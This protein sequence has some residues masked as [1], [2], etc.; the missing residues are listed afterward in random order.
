MSRILKLILYFFVYQLACSFVLTFLFYIPVVIR[1]SVENGTLSFPPFV[2]NSETTVAICAVTISNLLF[3]WH[4]I[5]YKYI[6]INRNILTFVSGKLYFF[7]IP[8]TLGLMCCLNYLTEIINLPDLN[9]SL[10]SEMKDSVLGII[11]IAIIAPV[12]EELFFRGTI[13]KHLLQIWKKPGY[14][15]TVSA[16]IFGLIHGNPAQIPYAFM[17]GLLLGWLYFR[18]GSLMPGIVVHFINNAL[19]LILMITLPGKADSMDSLFG[20]TLAPVIA[21]TGVIIA[22]FCFCYTQFILNKSSQLQKHDANNTR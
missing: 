6:N 16:L 21:T 15:I 20:E 5:R 14:G 17:L 2:S 18:T 8:L 22:L 3:A 1:Q 9:Q 19:S 4:L 12:V 7:L 13:E 11:S 10:F